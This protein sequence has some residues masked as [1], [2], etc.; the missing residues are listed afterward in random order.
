[1]KSKKYTT[2]EYAY[3]LYEQDNICFINIKMYYSTDERAS[4]LW[5]NSFSG[6]GYLRC[7]DLVPILE[8]IYLYYCMLYCNTRCIK[9][10]RWIL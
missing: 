8:N 3:D 6:F 9:F 5:I 10:Q 7:L 2:Y 1:M 4:T